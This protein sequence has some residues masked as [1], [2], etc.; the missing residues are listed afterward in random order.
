MSPSEG[1]EAPLSPARTKLPVQPSSRDGEVAKV[2]CGK[3]RRLDWRRT[4]RIAL[5]FG[6]AVVACTF[7]TPGARGQ[8]KKEKH[9]GLGASL[10]KLVACYGKPA[11]KGND[12]VYKG[13]TRYFFKNDA[14][15]ITALFV[16]DQ[17]G[18]ITYASNDKSKIAEEAFRELLQTN[19]VKGI[20]WQKIPI[21]NSF[22]WMLRGTKSGMRVFR[23]IRVGQQEFTFSDGEFLDQF[24]PPTPSD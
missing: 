15:S 22:V 14:L 1:S 10:E 2:G 16:K 7:L 4:V 9:A 24:Y 3:F 19:A 11:E 13:A 23:S 20:S 12:I 8:E 21:G 18:Q 17:C 5:S 6:A